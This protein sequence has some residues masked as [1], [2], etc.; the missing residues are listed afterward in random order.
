MINKKLWFSN[1]KNGKIQINSIV[2][3]QDLYPEIRQ[4]L[5]QDRESAS[6]IVDWIKSQTIAAF[7]VEYE[8]N[9][10]TGAL[11]NALGRWN[12]FIV[13]TLFSE[14]ALEFNQERAATIAIFSLPNSRIQA[15]QEG[16][17]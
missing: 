15:L 2:I 4:K 17:P 13:T 12:E 11:N 9:P 10:K 16:Q 7:K 6:Q 5:N 8:Q 3:Y 1:G 14:I